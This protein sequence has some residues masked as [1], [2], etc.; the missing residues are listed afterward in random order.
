MKLASIALTA[1]FCAVPAAAAERSVSRVLGSIDIA[2]NDTVGSVSTVNGAIEIGPH[3]SAAN[4]DTV[5]GHLRLGAGAS[6]NSLS[7]VNG[8]ITLEQDAHVKGGVSTVNGGLHLTSGAEVGGT[9]SNVNGDVLLIGAHV[10]GVLSTNT[11]SIQVMNGT[12]LDGGIHIER[13][14]HNW[15][16]FGWRTPR[17]VIGPGA[18]VAGPLTFDRKVVL[19]VSD[20]AVVTGA[21]AGATPIRYSG[22]LAPE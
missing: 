5:N 2:A 22:N 18:V 6:A 1:L 14:E 10:A 4:V 3:A 13:T 21:I 17:V 19:Y 20:R 8:G 12:R 11:G 16:I 9:L 15:G 7:T